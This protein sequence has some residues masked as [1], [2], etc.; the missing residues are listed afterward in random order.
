MKEILT[1]IAVGVIGI[2]MIAVAINFI[3]N[4]IEDSREKKKKKEK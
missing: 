1:W 4:L 3:A 2:S